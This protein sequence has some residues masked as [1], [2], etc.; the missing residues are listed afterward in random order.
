MSC[1]VPK[2]CLDLLT[3]DERER[4]PGTL[5][6]PCCLSKQKLSLFCLCYANSPDTTGNHWNMKPGLKRAS[7]EVPVT[8]A[9]QQDKR[10]VQTS[11]SNPTS[12]HGSWTIPTSEVSLFTTHLSD[13][14]SDGF[15]QCRVFV[16]GLMTLRQKPKMAGLNKMLGICNRAPLKGQSWG[17]GEGK[18]NTS[19]RL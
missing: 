15:D 16:Q 9:C 8:L 18:E 12:S 17:L 11:I 4:T 7:E 13:M 14:E 19:Y 5:P 3:R 1:P 2:G 6:A 10:A